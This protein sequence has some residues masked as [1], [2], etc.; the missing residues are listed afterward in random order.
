MAKTI[1]VAGFTA[2]ELFIHFNDAFK[3]RDVGVVG[4]HHL[5]DSMSYFPGSFL[6]D[7]NQSA[8][9]NGGDAFAG[10]DNEIDCL[11][12]LPQSQFC[13]MKWRSG[14]NSKLFFAPSAF[15]KPGPSA[16]AFD[17]I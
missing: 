15:I 2:D 3:H 10:A 7:T 13:A 8:Q 17:F 5:P 16:F 6:G 1:S 12:P 14:C 9:N 4:I 11:D